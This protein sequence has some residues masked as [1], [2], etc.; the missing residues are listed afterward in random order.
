MKKFLK[1]V[2]I[3]ILFI[4][5][6]APIAAHAEEEDSP[7]Y[8]EIFYH[9][10]IDR[11]NNGDPSLSEEVDINDE[12]TYQGGDLL[13]VTK[14]LDTLSE[15]GFTTIILSPV[16]QNAKRGYHGYW[17]EDFFD[18]E[19]QFG[20]MDDLNHLIK[21]A[22]GR[23]MKVVLELVT[24]YAAESNAIV[25]DSD[26]QDWFIDN[27]V[28]PIP[29]TEW[30]SEVV[31]FD[32][33]N[34]EVK[35]YLTEVVDFWMDETDIDGFKLHAADQASES[36][37]KD[38]TAH[39]KEKNPQFYLL[40]GTLQGDSF[41]D[42]VKSIE[43]IDIFEDVDMFE[44]LNEVFTEPDVP[45]S[46]LFETWQQLDNDN[47]ALYVDNINTAR[48][49]N[50]FA[51]M[52]RNSQT[53]WQLTLAF[54]YTAPGVPIVYQGSEIPMYGPGFPENQYIV[55]FIAGD[56]DLQKI[57]EKM[58]LIKDNYKSL[59]HGTFEQVATDEGM[60]L[61]KRTYDNESV[62]IAINNDSH[63]RNVAIDE[64]NED[65]QLRG[66]LQDHTVRENKDGL[67]RIGI[68]RESVEIFVVQPN[69]GLNWL[70]IGFVASVF[71]IF[72]GAIIW[73][74]RKQKRREKSNN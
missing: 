40:A 50:N 29:A 12:L 52:G 69:V 10:L 47:I 74:G 46:K 19:S 35:E 3:T 14:K 38:I 33:N 31:K 41:N 11:F 57:F 25:S 30:L 53:V 23:D 16:M 44:T 73:L 39:I 51:D 1:T 66:L 65:L 71:I 4:H 72:I 13:G 45:V 60:S 43:H 36:F 49:S 68:D 21:E 22:H 7:I 32:Q 56:Q 70:F 26:K 48:F 9:I 20:T 63:S 62:Y 8:D 37:L 15:L 18:V 28:E 54:L 61:F 17:I 27:D 24:N 58:S 5:T 2:L 55:D 42:T 59:S 64:L 6:V 67:F 34:D